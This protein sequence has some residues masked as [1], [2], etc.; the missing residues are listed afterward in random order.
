MTD[1]AQCISCGSKNVSYK[2]SAI[3]KRTSACVDCGADWDP[4]IVTDLKAFIKIIFKKDINL[5]D[6]SSRENF[7]RFYN[8]NDIRSGLQFDIHEPMEKMESLIAKR[9]SIQS[10]KFEDTGSPRIEAMKG[11]FVWLVIGI[12]YMMADNSVSPAIK[13]NTF[14]EILWALAAFMVIFG[15]G[16]YVKH[17]ITGTTSGADRKSNA[18]ENVNSDIS[19]LRKKYHK[20]YSYLA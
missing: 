15:V 8:K 7:F 13:D 16:M 17:M 4:E 1:Q 3:M 10:E 6:D 12:G 2:N 9:N 19:S 11:F 18:L 20:K 5:S 14:L